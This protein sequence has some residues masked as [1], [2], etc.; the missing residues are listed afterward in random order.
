MIVELKLPGGGTVRQT[1]CPI[2]FSETSPEYRHAGTPVGSNT[3]EVMRELGY[4]EGEID[5]F[6]KTGLFN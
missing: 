6:E 1:A 5:D 2:K 4:Q 3:R